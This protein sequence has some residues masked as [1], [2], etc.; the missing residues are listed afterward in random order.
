[1]ETCEHCDRQ[2]EFLRH[3]PTDDGSTILLCGWCRHDQTTP[4]FQETL[5]RRKDT[6][7]LGPQHHDKDTSI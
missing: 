2:S 4:E 1:M 6:I 3:V 7:Y 5:K